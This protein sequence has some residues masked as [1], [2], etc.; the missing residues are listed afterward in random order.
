MIK[1]NSKIFVAGH[2]GLVGNAIYRLFKKKG[3]TKIITTSRDKLD[4]TK[5]NKVLNFF[6]KQ[7]PEFVIMCAAKVGG[8]LENKNYQLDFLLENTEIQ[9]NILL[10][11]KK[12]K[13]KRVIFLG[14][15][16][17][18][19]KHSKIPIKEDYIMTGKLEKT[20]E[21]YAM[22]KL[23]GIKLSS[24][25]H[26]EFNQDIIC[27]MPT[28]LYG[29]KDNF[30][31]KSSHVI[32]GLIT[33]FL[34][35]KK[36]KTNIKVWGSGKAIREFMYV[37]DL[38]DAIFKTLITS[39]LRLTKIF[40]ERLP[41]INVGTG[42]YVSILQLAKKIKKILKFNGKILFDKNFPDGTKIKNL[43]SSKIRKLKWKPKIK[44]DTGLKKVINSRIKLT[45]E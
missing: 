35:A 29:I 7:R 24:I 12:F 42:E 36:N 19:P 14:S 11:A 38:A 43:D 10:S 9:N 4:L 18:Y 31:I 30:D 39:K 28:N 21:A 2:N 8:I 15:S 40:E 26:E 17:I 22:S 45:N 32:P 27:L 6:E 34:N 1:K 5:K 25:L 33:K 41:I 16:C 20:N 3:Y 44:L 37:D 13:V 23:Y